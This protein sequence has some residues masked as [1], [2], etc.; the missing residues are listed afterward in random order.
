MAEP[1][2]T[3]PRAALSFLVHQ[4][5]SQ[6][7][8]AL[9]FLHGAGEGFLDDAPGV[10]P[11]KQAE[12]LKN[13]W[14]L[15]PPEL[16]SDPRS[17]DRAHPLRKSLVTIAPQLSSRQLGWDAPGV[18]TE[19]LRMLEA[20]APELTIFLLG[21]SKGGKGAFQ[22][23]PSLSARAIFTI[24]ASHMGDADFSKVADGCETPHWCVYTE[25]AATDRLYRN[26]TQLHES[27]ST[28]CRPHN[29]GLARPPARNG[30]WK[31]LV[32]VSRWARN[33]H[34][35]ICRVASRQNSPYD[36][37]LSHL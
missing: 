29:E 30:Y 3:S 18:S 20:V 9:V 6:P 15:G 8:A 26:V 27:M 28:R 14:K 10:K 31:S 23:A 22:L 25:H 2:A 34:A 4:P 1:Q 13:L 12:G 36:W 32:P 24:D 35:E 37:L 16:L 11:E 7:R 17:L 33:P 19:I 5:L 21:F